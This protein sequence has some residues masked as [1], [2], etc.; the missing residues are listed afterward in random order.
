MNAKL[1][2]RIVV[3][4][5]RRGC[6]DEPA[7]FGCCGPSRRQREREGRCSFAGHVGCEAQQDQ[8]EEA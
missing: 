6:A 5:T 1:D 3:A 7:S 4:M 2:A 8:R